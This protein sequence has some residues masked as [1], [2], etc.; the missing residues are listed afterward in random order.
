[1]RLSRPVFGYISPFVFGALI[2][3]NRASAQSADS[4]DLSLLEALEVYHNSLGDQAAI[5][6]GV[7][8]RRYPHYLNYGHPFFV[9]DSLAVGSVIYDD[10]NYDNVWL[11]YDEVNDELITRDWQ[12][13]NLVQLHKNSVSS[14]AIGDNKFLNIKSDLSL[15]AGYYRVL[16]GGRSAV[17]AREA[18]TIHVRTVRPGE[19]ERSVFA[20]TDFYLKTPKGYEKFSRLTSLLGF[21]GRHRRAVEKHLASQKVR[22]RLV[23]EKAFVEAAKYYDTITN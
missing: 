23:R 14:F 16:Y 6:N 7:Q 4:T 8:Y 3:L 10:I 12:G 9:A 2:I 20:S 19:T 1:M 5:Y 18:K 11:M 15:K 21:F 13:D 22:Q 17:L